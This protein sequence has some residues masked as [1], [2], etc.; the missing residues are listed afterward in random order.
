SKFSILNLLGTLMG[1]DEQFPHFMCGSTSP[2]EI[3]FGFI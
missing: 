3:V 1:K 2:N